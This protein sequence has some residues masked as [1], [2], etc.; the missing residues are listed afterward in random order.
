MIHD[1]VLIA[2]C[3]ES[4]KYVTYQLS[5]AGH[6]PAMA[7]TGNRESGFDFGKGA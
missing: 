4:F 5:M 2:F 7:V 3:D 6:W 1:K